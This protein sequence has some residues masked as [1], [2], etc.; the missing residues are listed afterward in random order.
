MLQSIHELIRDAE[1]NYLQ[2][3]TKISEHV[4]WSMKDTIDT[5]D[6]YI[7][8]KHTSGLYDAL[9]RE[10]PFFNIVTAAVNIWY[11]ATD[12]DR[13]NIRILPDKTSNTG[14]AF[15]ATILLNQWMKKA[16][17]GVFL[18]EWGRTLAKY[19]SAVVKFVEK[20]GELT[21][22]V[23]PWNRFIADP[24]QFE[25]IPRIEKLYMTPAQLR[26]N[27]MYDQSTVDALLYSAAARKT[28][29]GDVK[30]NKNDF[31]EIYEVHGEL[32]TRL[33]QDD[34]D[35]GLEDKDIKYRQQ[36]HVV[37]YIESESGQYDD[38]TL[39][40]GKE[41][42]DPYMIT[43]LI[44][45]D[46]RTLSIG[47]V[48]HL[49]EAQWMTNHSVK[50]MKDTLDI[51][52]KLIFQTADSNITGK[53]VL[54]ALQS[55]EIILHADNK[56]LTRLANDKPD[57]TAMMNFRTM[58]EQLGQ[59][60]TATPDAMR[61]DTPPSGTPYSTTALI[62]QQSNSLFEI[63]TENKGLV[64]E[65]MLREHI[66]PH[67]KK[68]MDTKDE[69]VAILEAEQI[70]ELDAMY[71]PA[72]ARRRYNQRAKE[73]MISGTIPPTFDA[74]TEEQTVRRELETIGNRR[75]FA[76][77]D[78]GEATWDK[79]L[80]DFEWNVNVEVTNENTDKQ[81]VLATLSAV[82]QTI[83][84]NPAILQDPNAKMVFNTILTETGRLSPLQLTTTSSQTVPQPSPAVG[85]AGEALQ[86]LTPQPNVAA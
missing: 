2:G 34:P 67:L 75:T 86:N 68:K 25:A 42:K 49:F 52:S 28:L 44:P 31:I 12:I 55:G 53:N 65:D 16:R 60:L 66:I 62:T 56:P 23:V 54:S 41:A 51:A 76:P 50:A 58:W 29:N 70:S 13:K 5:I 1:H 36:M 33:L 19:G 26:K 18:N 21:A 27:P 32:D 73:M 39:Y 43:H 46:G 57:I 9:G 64:I 6:A 71:V 61:G 69:I 83:A 22:Q 37:S 3:S 8:S 7:N 20:D 82:L 72:E 74:Q 15:I 10:K 38:F 40:S 84:S 4:N 45:E 59:G 47:A 77:D 78:I 85:G 14:L 63:M 35:W 17:F 30:D 81:A 24:V 11:R 48:E 79:A 80:K